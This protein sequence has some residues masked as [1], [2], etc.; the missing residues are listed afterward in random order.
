VKSDSF[1]RRWVELARLLLSLSAGAILII[2]AFIT[3]SP[4]VPSAKQFVLHGLRYFTFAL[5][6][7]IG[8]MIFALGNELDVTWSRFRL[9]CFYMV[10]ITVMIGWIFF[11]AGFVALLRFARTVVKSWPD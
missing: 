2:A 9:F 1:P 11:A 8:T 4:P 6:L 5:L 7:F 3:D 10:R